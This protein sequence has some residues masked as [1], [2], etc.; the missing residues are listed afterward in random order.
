MIDFTPI[1]QA[2][3]ALIAALVAYKVVPWLKAHTTESQ[4]AHLVSL[5]RTL[6]F[7]AEQIYGAG[8]GE[9]KLSWVADRMKERGYTVDFAVIEAM[10][11]EL[12]SEGA[13]VE[14]E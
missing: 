8:K 3:I 6:V 14:A 10:V 4:Y 9:E 13:A 1:I 12:T 2:V 7:A 11:R 5:T